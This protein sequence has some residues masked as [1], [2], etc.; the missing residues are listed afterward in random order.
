[1][2]SKER[3]TEGTRLTAREM[4]QDSSQVNKRGR[5]LFKLRDQKREREGE[6]QRADLRKKKG[7]N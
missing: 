1:M 7:M 3:G 6:K 2:R 5:N 4:K